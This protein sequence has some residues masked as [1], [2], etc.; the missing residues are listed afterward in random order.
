MIEV[1]E[2]EPAPS[3]PP[4]TVDGGDASGGDAGSQGQGG[5]SEGDRAGS[6]PGPAGRELGAGAENIGARWLRG[7]ALSKVSLATPPERGAGGGRKGA[8]QTLTNASDV[9]AAQAQRGDTQSWVA[10]S[11]AQDLGDAAATPPLPVR[12]SHLAMP[13]DADAMLQQLR[14]AAEQHH[15]DALHRGR[16]LEA[17]KA[18]LV[19][20]QAEVAR[21]REEL[22][23]VLAEMSKRDSSFELLDQT[24][25]RVCQ[26]IES[27][28]ERLRME[29]DLHSNV[30]EKRLDS[31]LRDIEDLKLGLQVEVN[32]HE[33]AKRSVQSLC[34]KVANLQATIVTQDAKIKN[35]QVH[36][37][38][39]Q[40]WID[41]LAG[42]KKMAEVLGERQLQTMRDQERTMAHYL[43]RIEES[44]EELRAE[45]EHHQATKTVVQDL[46]AHLAMQAEN[47]EAKGRETKKLSTHCEQL[48]IKV[49]KL[50]EGLSDSERRYSLLTEELVSSKDLARAKEDELQSKSFELDASLRSLEETR[51]ELKVAKASLSGLV[52]ECEKAETR[53][54]QSL[55]QKE[56]V[57]EE[58]AVAKSTG[59]AERTELRGKLCMAEEDLVKAKGDAAKERKRALA[60][61][62]Q[63][64]VA[65]AQEVLLTEELQALL[66]KFRERKVKDDK[67]IKKLEAHA[68]HLDIKVGCLHAPDKV[69]ELGAKLLEQ[70]KARLAKLRAAQ[71]ATIRTLVAEHEAKLVE[72]D[73]EVKAR[74]AALARPLEDRVKQLTERDREAVQR[75]KHEL[76]VC[77]EKVRDMDADYKAKVDELR[78]DTEA[79]LRRANDELNSERESVHAMSRERAEAAA[80]EKEL[81]QQLS[82]LRQDAA[83]EQRMMRE[84]AKDH[85]IERERLEAR[86]LEAQS[87]NRK[88]REALEA[89]LLEVQSRAQKDHE[90]LEKRLLEAQTNGRNEVREVRGILQAELKEAQ[91]TIKKLSYEVTIQADLNKQTEKIEEEHKRRLDEVKAAGEKQV[92]G[93]R[94]DL[95]ERERRVEK[96]NDKLAAARDEIEELRAKVPRSILKSFEQ[97]DV[98]VPSPPVV[99]PPS[100]NP[101]STTQAS[102]RDGRKRVAFAQGG[103]RERDAGSI[104]GGGHT[105]QLSSKPP[106][107][108]RR[109][110]ASSNTTP[111]LTP[112]RPHQA[113]NSRRSTSALT[114]SSTPV[115][116]PIRTPA[117]T[118]TS[119]RKPVYTDPK[120]GARKTAI[121]LAGYDSDD[122]LLEDP[123]DFDE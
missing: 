58:L 62:E 69:R 22:A 63:I 39:L 4:G 109:A 78:I 44:A 120:K 42:E 52:D 115:T 70:E 28:E 5:G 35:A 33:E 114:P 100:P 81:R 67:A 26:E 77:R 104:K 117:S 17:T 111:V 13:G 85:A 61:Q 98:G 54:A 75:F 119:T 56:E 99:E 24:S 83:H 32:A 10:T 49:M 15:H 108:R 46:K 51:E 9:A 11:V 30:M 23:G 59:E 1:H 55:Q 14:T 37:E 7:G 101:P 93:I 72:K 106:V 65:K 110:P 25:T 50:Q 107:K 20:S 41:V 112:T 21:L 2:D 48:G 34:K 103:N 53:L 82:R 36:A 3:S 73:S 123:F 95:E 84:S 92:A 79:A 45:Q 105:E 97:Q 122:G 57:E 80:R 18:E 86:L 19:E 31:Q 8:L 29:E 88:K 40:G 43:Q 102:A 64:E 12:S 90:T 113:A 94:R 60:F 38:G 76:S 89:R 71:E 118:P 66:A 27:I 96:L 74:A 91:A 6:A 87:S 68:S 16:M 116:P 121:D 47:L